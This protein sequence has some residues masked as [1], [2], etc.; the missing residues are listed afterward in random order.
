MSKNIA[1][2]IDGTWNK[3]DVRPGQATNV[4]KLAGPGPLS[5]AD[6]AGD[7]V[8][9][10]A[11]RFARHDLPDGFLEARLAESDWLLD[12][13][14]ETVLAPGNTPD[15]TELEVD[16]MLPD[17]WLEDRHLNKTSYRRRH[18]RGVILPY[19]SEHFLFDVLEQA[20][21]TR[22]ERND[23]WWREHEPL[24][25]RRRDL[26]LRY[27][28]IQAYRSNPEAN[29][30][31]AAAQLCDPDLLK[32][33]DL[34]HELGEL[35]QDLYPYVESAAQEKH[36]ILVLAL[37]KSDQNDDWWEVRE[38]G[39]Y[40][41]LQWVPRP[42]RLS[43]TQL[44]LDR[45]EPRFGAGLPM[46]RLHMWDST[47]APPIS[48]E[49]LLNLS[50]QGVV[51]L[52]EFFD[53]VDTDE[54][55][56]Y[57]HLGGRHA[58]Q[59]VFRDATEVAPIHMLGLAKRLQAACVHTGY[60]EAIA[61]GVTNHLRYR[62]ANVSRS[63]GQPPREPLPDGEDLAVRLL[64]LID[65]YPSL[66][67]SRN[68]IS[69]ACEA[70][71]HILLED[72]AVSRLISFLDRFSRLPEDRKRAARSRAEGANNDGNERLLHD[73]INRPRGVAAGAAVQCC[74]HLIE[75]QRPVPE[76]LVQ[77]VLTFAGD[78]EPST[79]V[80]VLHRL[81]YMVWARPDIGWPAFELIFQQHPEIPDATAAAMWTYAEPVLYCQY[82]MHYERVGP[83]LARVR[84]EAFTSAAETYGR[85]AALSSLAGHVSPEEIFAA[86]SDAPVGAW[87]GTAQVLC[88]NL[89]AA[90]HRA[91]CHRGL[92]SL[93]RS[94]EAPI[95]A[96]SHIAHAF[97]GNGSGA[98]L[99]SEVALA[100][101]LASQSER[102]TSKNKREKVQL[103]GVAD[104]VAHEASRNPLSAL[105]VVEA[106]TT[107]LEQENGLSLYNAEELVT[108][109]AAA[110]RE[111]DE[112]EDRDLLL[113]VL[114]V[115]DRLLRLGISEVDELLNRAARP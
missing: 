9:L 109:L 7:T 76:L 27:L 24:L 3:A 63:G 22:A 92:L 94:P 50:G 67:E 75:H 36:Q 74:N 57:E 26:A 45:F 18:V 61:D 1:L 99:N 53:P 39:V 23:V 38:R 65:E 103:S 56:R 73:A 33:A 58:L 52:A 8:T 100:L 64:Q 102:S 29:G 31:G 115:Q 79:R 48:T 112:L 37:H 11:L 40:E 82:R 5:V 81:A 77:V 85:I 41:Y 110:L 13:F 43:E 6:D 114:S 4:W 111:A 104:W 105:T 72:T 28:L 30:E 69:H 10:G 49:Q 32:A 91:E 95:E 12:R 55:D 15:E 96:L 97:R 34:R 88:A 90:V 87:K 20:L 93:L 78:P 2:F 19:D 25:R 80:G 113:R 60:I 106:L 46:P 54:D 51:R 21:K 84:S 70:C 68:T 108:A 86:L 66:W 101:I 16:E 83:L 98:Y 71:A 17:N 47:T 59:R 14:L 89:D 42:F 62:F 35:T 44:V 107:V